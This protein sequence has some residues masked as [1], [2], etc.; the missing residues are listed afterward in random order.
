[1]RGLFFAVA[2][3]ACIMHHSSA[4]SWSPEKADLLF[5]SGKNG[6]ADIYVKKEGTKE[7]VNLTNHPDGDNWPV[8]SPDGKRVLFQRQTAKYFDLW[9]VN[10]DGSNQIQ[11]TNNPDHEYL[12]SWSPDGN[13]ITFTSWRKEAADTGRAP[14]IYI[15]NSD[16]T[17]QRRLVAQT[18]NTSAGAEW[19]PDGK[20]IVFS[21]R[22]RGEGADIFIAKS[23]GTDERRITE[24]DSYNGS[25]V[26]SP[27]GSKI[28]FYFD[29]GK[30]AQ[31]VVMNLDGSGRRVLV[32]EGY[33]W[34]P[35][36]SPDGQWITYT[37]YAPEDAKNLE[38]FAVSVSGSEGPLRI[39]GSPARESES[40]WNPA[41]ILPYK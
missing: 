4:Q 36:W 3:L 8:W 38:I 15:M 30:G 34:Y 12:P 9:V 35:R 18:V 26:F 25:P 19:S 5:T 21:R 16:G 28:A 11:L 40:S 14:H 2:V 27:D 24:S 32:A 31:I 37:A 10:A 33:N 23:D 13:S 17:G 22:L 7:W 20:Y 39:A 29:T 6:N 41:Q 1:M